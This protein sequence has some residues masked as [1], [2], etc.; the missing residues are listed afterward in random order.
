M[1]NPAERPSPNAGANDGAGVKQSEV[2][3][4]TEKKNLELEYASRLKSEV[5]S[6]L[7]HELRSPL[8]AIIGF[9]EAL[10][11]GLLGPMSDAQRECIG[12]IF[13]GGQHLLSLINAATKLPH[14]VPG[15]LVSGA[16]AVTLAA[17]EPK[18]RIALVVDD[19]DQAADLLRLFL[20]AE[21]FSVLR[22]VYAE[23]ALLLVRQHTFAL[24]TL[25]LELSDMNGWQFLL[26]LRESS[27][28]HAP[29]VIVSGRPVGELAQAR[30][31]AAMLLKPVS[32]G[33]LKATLAELGLLVPARNTP[34][35]LIA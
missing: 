23:D 27:S 26:Q 19:E 4:A 12:N 32:R 21:G 29:V 14:G 7:S 10:R 18:A 5:M 9:S 11:D 15:G 16:G 13:A 2:D 31:A 35:Q 8:N 25:D 1:M 6:T 22:A 33:E 24:I 28:Q 20:E 17:V 30:G 3:G 34:A